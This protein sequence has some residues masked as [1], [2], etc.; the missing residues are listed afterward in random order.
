[1]LRARQKKNVQKIH[2]RN[3]GR[4]GVS[5][6]PQLIG[7]GGNKTPTLYGGRRAAGKKDER[8]G[9]FGEEPKKYRTYLTSTWSG[10]KGMFPELKRAKTGQDITNSRKVRKGGLSCGRDT[11]PEEMGANTHPRRGE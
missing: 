2:V 4:K 1:L 6:G 10:G 3:P 8:E 7:G 9:Y 5:E 11:L